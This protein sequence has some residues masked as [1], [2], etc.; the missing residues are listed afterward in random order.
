M[1]YKVLFVSKFL[2]F[3]LLVSNSWALDKLEYASVKR[4]AE[5]VKKACDPS[6]CIL[7]GLGRSPAPIQAYFAA[8]GEQKGYSW[9]LPLSKFRYG[10]SQPKLNAENERALYQHFDTYLPDS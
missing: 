4:V 8:T 3:T 7:I 6:D 10:V 9:N 5:Q 1:K 2:V